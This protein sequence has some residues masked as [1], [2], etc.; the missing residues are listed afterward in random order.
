MS[1]ITGFETSPNM[2]SRQSLWKHILRD[3]ANTHTMGSTHGKGIAYPLRES[4]Q[5]HI[6]RLHIW[7]PL[8]TSLQTSHLEI[9]YLVDLIKSHDFETSQNTR[10]EVYQITRYQ[11]FPETPNM[12]S[13]Q[14]LWKLML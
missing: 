11:V 5:T 4:L 6:S 9:R 7:R 12:V 1:K 14:S 2:V 13:R 10:S 3:Y 8:R